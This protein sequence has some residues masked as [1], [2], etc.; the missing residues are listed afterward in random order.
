MLLFFLSFSPSPRLLFFSCFGPF[1]FLRFFFFF[2]PIGGATGEGDRTSFVGR[3]SAASAAAARFLRFFR[4]PDLDLDLTA[5]GAAAHTVCRGFGDGEAKG[6]SGSGLATATPG[7]I[8]WDKGEALREQMSGMGD[9]PT[10]DA[11]GETMA[12]LAGASKPIA[13]TSLSTLCEA[14]R[15]HL[16]G[17]SGSSAASMFVD[18]PELRDLAR[19]LDVLG[20]ATTLSSGAT[21][22]RDTGAGVKGSNVHSTM[23]H[24]SRLPPG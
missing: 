9:V 16:T 19:V 13:G 6:G 8:T 18:P 14:D 24:V 10:G 15:R 5:P 20:L 3:T 11:A 23:R 2:S 7:G 12:L 1:S 22:S 4:L 21:G 17:T